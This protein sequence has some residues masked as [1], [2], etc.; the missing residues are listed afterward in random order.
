MANATPPTPFDPSAIDPAVLQQFL[1]IHDWLS[2]GDTASLPLHA[3]EHHQR[4]EIRELQRVLL[5]AHLDR[6]GTGDVGPALVVNGQIYNHRRIH[7]RIIRTLAGE[8]R[9]DRLAYSRDGSGSIHPLDEALQLPARSFSYDLQKHLAKAAVQGPFQESLDRI[10][11]IAGFRIHKR[12]LEAIVQEA[13][14]DF[15]DSYLQRPPQVP[16]PKA[17][18]LVVS[19]DG[20]GIPLV[21]PAPLQRSVRPS[22]GPKPGGKKMATVATVFYRAPWIRTPDQ[23]VESLFRTTIRPNYSEQPPRP[24][25]KRVWASLQKTKADVIDEV[26]R[27]VLRRDPDSHKTRV[28]LTDGDRSLQALV[29][30]KLEVTLILDLLHVL[31]YVWQAAHVLCPGPEDGPE[32]EIYARLACSRILEGNVCQVIKGLRQTAT[33]RRLLGTARETLLKVANYFDHNK[34]HMRYHDYLAQGLPIASGSVE[35]ACKHLIK[36]R[37]ER[38]G[39]RWTEPMAEA[40]VK[41]RAIYLSGDFDDYWP[42]HIKQDQARLHPKG[43]WSPV[44]EK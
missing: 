22:K 29:H 36:D 5:Q 19:L 13:A 43:R 15:D 24:E 17:S 25:H 3:I 42:Y 18:L 10:E 37:M 9:I 1:S 2:D 44:V 27:E 35:G 40:I 16:D 4:G 41:L 20:K 7:P 8:V 39:M 14:R 21:R 6:R 33:K 30:N 11:D 23:V 28:A 12:S 32:V 34:Q 38:S 26:L 31:G